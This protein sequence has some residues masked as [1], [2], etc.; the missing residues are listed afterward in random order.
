LDIATNTCVLI[1]FDGGSLDGGDGQL[2]GTLP[3]LI[4]VPFFPP[5]PP[6]TPSPPSPLDP[7]RSTTTVAGLYPQFNTVDLSQGFIGG[8]GAA[9]QGCEC[10]NGTQVRGAVSLAWG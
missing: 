8:Q 1:A 10:N 3:P 5:P 2:T 4:N 7:R 9:Q 6:P